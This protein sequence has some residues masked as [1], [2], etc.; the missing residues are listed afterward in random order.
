MRFSLKQLIFVF[1]FCFIVCFY[2]QAAIGDSIDYNRDIRPVLS[3]N[4]FSCH[5]PD[6][7]TR[8]AGLR[9]D[10]R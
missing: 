3:R 10:V 7:G 2:N 4:C 9:L 5:G 1:G 8:K 6:D